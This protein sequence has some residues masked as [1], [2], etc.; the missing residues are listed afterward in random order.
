MLFQSTEVSKTSPLNGS[1]VSDATVKGLKHLSMV[2]E[3]ALPGLVNHGLP[4]SPTFYTN[5]RPAL[6]WVD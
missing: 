2:L 4:K 1:V 3:K 5:I 6:T